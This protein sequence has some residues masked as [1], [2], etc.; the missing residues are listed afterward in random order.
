MQAD[1]EQAGAARCAYWA[2]QMQR[3]YDVVQDVLRF[4][5]EEC[6]EPFASL[7]DAAATAA[8]EMQFSETRIA[9]TL[10]RVFFMRE[11]L[12]RRVVDVGRAL[13][14]RGWILKIEDA[15][16]SLEMQRQLVLKPA[17]FDAI[18]D[19]CIWECGGRL[20]PVE[21]VARRSIVLIANIPKI[22][23]HMS[24]S[25]IDISVLRRDDG[26]EVWRGEPYLHM[27]ERTP[28]RSPFVEPAALANRLAITDVLEA[29]GFIHFPF[30]FWH[31]NQDDA[32]GHVVSGTREPAR[33]GPVEWD[34]A[35]NRVERCANPLEPLNALDVIER[36]LQAALERARQA[37][38]PR[39]G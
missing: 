36:E 33:F 7:R 18:L 22:G 19:K 29:H 17:V 28:M 24:G 38:A 37:E 16:R 10:E 8:V 35:T 30:E 23:T 39:A 3:G 25:A 34:P 2:E 15:Y 20:P 31:Y 9:G 32:L 12:V 21:L 6:G 1:G 27:S 5:V 13:N 4:P 14:A 11:S 26:T